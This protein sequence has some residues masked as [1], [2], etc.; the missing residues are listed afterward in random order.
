[1]FEQP[2]PE[3]LVK[4]FKNVSDVV[5]V[6]EF[7]NLSSLNS[8]HY[9]ILTMFL[10]SGRT[11]GPYRLLLLLMVNITTLL[12]CHGIPVQLHDQITAGSNTSRYAIVLDAGSSK[13]KLIVYKIDANAPPLD[14]KDIQ[15]LGGFKVK[16][17]LAS[18][19]GNP[20]AVDGY[21]KPL[22]DAAMKIVPVAK[23]ASTP[24][25]LFATAGM[26]LIR[27]RQSDAIMNKVKMLFNDKAKCPFTFN[28]ETDVKV[29]S[30]AF[31]GIYA[32]ISLNFLKGRFAPGNSG[33]TFGILEIGGASYQNTFENPSKETIAL[34]VAGK[35][36]HLFAR[37]YLGYGLNEA[38][39]RHF[40]TLAKNPPVNGVLQSP[41]H[42]NG[43]QDQISIS[44]RMF[45]I[46]GTAQV[47]ECRSIIQQTFFCKSPNCPFYDQ[48]KLPGDFF[49]FS[50]IFYAAHGTGMINCWHCTKPLSPAMY[51]VSSRRFCAKKYHEVSSDPYAK[52]TC[53][54][55][56]FVYELLSQGYGLPADKL[57]EVGNQ[58]NGFN[59]GWTLGAML[60]N[61]KML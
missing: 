33:S 6:T 31:E 19:A 28:P 25:F 14:V 32:W 53:F 36:Y 46:R 49:G 56:N 4:H 3:D 23:H 50:G 17:G 61:M 5:T 7:V 10:A 2:G 24:I 12:T 15:L 18:L 45:T 9:I 39:K 54:S 44:G 20:S 59:V 55:S 42:H 35:P 43:F 41:C 1:M 16:P 29:V 52:N 22:L 11:M 8:E 21:L 40:E 26:R 38:R 48:P 47:E 58:V 51:D 60:Y 37:S 13:T 30:G 27:K 34:T 57:I